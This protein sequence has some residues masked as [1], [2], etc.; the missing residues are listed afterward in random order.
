MKFE[1]R[2]EGHAVEAEDGETVLDAL[3]RVGAH[4]PFSCKGG[5]C[6]TCLSQCTEGTVPAASQKGLAEH[7]RQA[8]YFLPCKCVPETPM[9]MRPPQPEDMI[10]GC[11]LCEVA[12]SEAGAI[13]IKFEPMRVLSYR[14]GQR[15]RLIDDQGAI[16]PELVLDALPGDD[17]T[18]EAE[19][20]LPEGSVKPDWLV[21]DAP[22]GLEFSVRGPF[23]AVE[24]E[25]PAPTPDPGLWEELDQGRK[26]RAV[27]QAFYAKVYADTQLSPFFERSTM[28]RAIDKQY[29]FL[30]QCM[31]GEKMYFGD[32]PRNAHHWMI[33]TPAMFD[34]RQQIM[35]ETLR[36]HGLSESQISR[37]TRFEEHYRGDIVKD[38]AWPRRV[39]GQDVITEGFD[40][41]TLGEAT[42]CDHCGSE[43][44]KGE[45]VL[46]HRRLGTVSCHACSSGQQSAGVEQA[47]HA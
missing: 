5:S 4:M 39:G 24:G 14:P 35:V 25:R 43:V 6:Q 34:H 47:Q 12:V 7:L 8:H 44:A 41:E 42:I 22:F 26:V 18:I 30:M 11:M 15:L 9:A 40:R 45:T 36:E 13:R 21:P 31:T 23:E 16:E 10:T 32:R 2:Y 20:V 27:L 46:Y 38:K 3:L 17:M 33:I 28:E 1:L 37:W 29:S 19:L